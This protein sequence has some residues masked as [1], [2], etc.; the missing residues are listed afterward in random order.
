MEDRC[1]VCGEIIPEGIQVCPA[2]MNRQYVIRP[3]HCR[4]GAVAR[5]RYRIPVTWVECKKKC[6]MMTGYYVDGYEQN[7]LE[8][9]EKAILEWNRMMQHG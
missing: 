3:V 5:I 6:G 8:A 2:C 1:L 9:K 7:D 4:C